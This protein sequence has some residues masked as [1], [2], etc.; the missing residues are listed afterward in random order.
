[1]ISKNYLKNFMKK[2]LRKKT[3]KFIVYEIG[4]FEF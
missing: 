2:S 3:Y 1:M 4:Y